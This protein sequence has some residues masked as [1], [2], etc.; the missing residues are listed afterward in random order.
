MR[1]WRSMLT[2]WDM[3]AKIAI[4]RHVA[5]REIGVCPCFSVLKE[6]YQSDTSK[7][8]CPRKTE[9]IPPL[10]SAHIL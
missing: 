7:N 10:E 6:H 8:S 4:Y 1:A 5:G 2:D 9:T 3:R